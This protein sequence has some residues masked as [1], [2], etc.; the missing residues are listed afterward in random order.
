[1]RVACLVAAGL[2][3]AAQAPALAQENCGDAV[4]AL[5]QR[6]S[7]AL[8]AANADTPTAPSAPATK[9]SLGVGVMDRLEQPDAVNRPP[10]G[11]SGSTSPAESEAQ[12]S[13]RRI[14]AEALLNEARQ[15]AEAG[16]TAEC[17]MKLDNARPLLEATGN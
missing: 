4:T 3:L 11:G 15:D 5:A 2:V 9:E 10:E 7:I 14:Q 16:R 1:M 13:A 12:A 8:Q 6:H 17:R